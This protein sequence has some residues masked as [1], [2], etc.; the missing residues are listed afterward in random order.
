MTPRPRRVARL[1]GALAAGVVALV[2]AANA[3]VLTV[4]G[5]GV[6]ERGE[7]VPARPVAIVLGARVW[8]DGTPSDVLED[9]LAV[10][11]DLYRAGRVRR[12][13]G[14]GDNGANRYDEVTVMQRWLLARGV[15]PKHVVRDH[16]GFRTLDSMERAARVFQVRHAVVCTQRF[17]M[18]RS[19]FLA[20]HAGLD[21]VG[22]VADRRRYRGR[23]RFAIREVGARAMAVVD[24]WVLRR[25]PRFLGPPIPI[26]P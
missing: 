5:R 12:I 11:L 24:A 8:R 4:G 15:D 14:P 13:L 25:G 7:V 18:A 3:V 20:R 26:E 16:A 9:R 19:L 1:A 23:A 22:A 2:V 6:Y 21:A 17:H 10:A